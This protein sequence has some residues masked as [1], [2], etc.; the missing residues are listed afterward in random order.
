MIFEFNRWI[1]RLFGTDGSILCFPNT[2]F[3][4]LYVIVF[5]P[6]NQAK[7]HVKFVKNGLF[8]NFSRPFRFATASKGYA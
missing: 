7:L 8:L 4:F 1:R 5:L 2:F 3:N 6:I